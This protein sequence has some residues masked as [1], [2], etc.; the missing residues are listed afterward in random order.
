MTINKKTFLILIAFVA[1]FRS[2]MAQSSV[3][4]NPLVAYDKN[5]KY[6]V[7]ELQYDLL[8]LKDALVKTHPGLF[9]Y[10]TEKEFEDNYIKVKNSIS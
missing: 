3:P 8:I 1:T 6:S 10:Q 7:S 9:W 4:N 5:K 2:T